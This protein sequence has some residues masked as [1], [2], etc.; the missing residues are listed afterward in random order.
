MFL[1]LFLLGF[2]LASGAEPAPGRAEGALIVKF[3]DA[4]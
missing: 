4:A 3:D 2:A 1:V